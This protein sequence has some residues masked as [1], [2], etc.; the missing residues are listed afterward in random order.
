MAYSDEAEPVL[1]G[2]GRAPGD[3]RIHGFNASESSQ[4]VEA[5]AGAGLDNP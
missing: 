3:E 2:S 1:E 5:A 4:Q